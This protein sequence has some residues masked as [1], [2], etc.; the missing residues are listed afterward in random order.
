MLPGIHSVILPVLHCADGLVVLTATENNDSNQ[1]GG[2]TISH[3]T[4]GSPLLPD[5]DLKG[6]PPQ[7]VATL[8]E[9]FLCDAWSMFY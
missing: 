7:T 2:L 3:T 6:L 9:E 4:D 8:L 5:V 1:S